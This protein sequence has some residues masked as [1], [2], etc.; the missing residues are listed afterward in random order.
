MN[1]PATSP[2][3]MLL[4]FIQE[5]GR[6]V[7]DNRLPIQGLAAE[8]IT[9]Q[10]QDPAFRLYEVGTDE[11]AMLDLIKGDL[12]FLQDMGFVECDFSNPHVRLTEWGRF[13]ANLLEL[14]P[15]VH[16]AMARS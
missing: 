13:F 12:L 3:S 10:Q 4:K 14:P 6:R 9:L 2:D 15:S 7:E 16:E 5:K 8:L 11:A 1:Y